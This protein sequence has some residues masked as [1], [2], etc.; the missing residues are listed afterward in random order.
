MTHLAHAKDEALVLADELVPA[1][2]VVK[3]SDILGIV[4]ECIGN[5]ICRVVA[6]NLLEYL[7]QL[8]A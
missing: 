5:R 4:D 1:L 2:A 3:C 8:L 7:S 6:P